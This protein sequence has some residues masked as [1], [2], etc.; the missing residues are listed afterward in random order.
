MQLRHVRELRHRREHYMS[1]KI[2]Y[3]M[4]FHRNNPLPNVSL[5]SKTV[6]LEVPPSSKNVKHLEGNNDECCTCAND[7]SLVS[8]FSTGASRYRAILWSWLRMRRSII[9]T[10]TE[11]WNNNILLQVTGTLWKRINLHE[12]RTI[13]DL[14]RSVYKF[15]WHCGDLDRTWKGKWKC[16]LK[17]YRPK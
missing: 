17:V 13:L 3:T 7:K 9:M 2:L 15:A 5:W 12:N 16:Y 4:Q 14:V 8:I 10:L 11:S 1:R 6:I